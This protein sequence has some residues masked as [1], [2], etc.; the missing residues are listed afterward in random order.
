MLKLDDTDR[1][2]LALLQFD[3]K[4]NIKASGCTASTLPKHRFMTGSTDTKKKAL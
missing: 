2:L 1:Q 4:V 3:S